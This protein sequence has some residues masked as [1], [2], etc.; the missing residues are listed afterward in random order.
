MRWRRSYA[1]PQ[2]SKHAKP[3]RLPT[4][5]NDTVAFVLEMFLRLYRQLCKRKIRFSARLDFYDH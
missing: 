4:H 5:I 1:R 2:L 3:F